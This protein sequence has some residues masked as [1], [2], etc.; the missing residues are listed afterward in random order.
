M[1]IGLNSIIFIQMIGF[2]TLL[3]ILNVILY[4]PV[5]R[6]IRERKK[7]IEN[8]LNQAGELQ[9]KASENEKAYK[10]KFEKSEASAK[11]EYEDIVLSALKEKEKTIEEE[12]AK[13]IEVIE[14]EKKEILSALSFELTKAKQ[15]SD[16]ISNK[17]YEQLVA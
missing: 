5:L 8:L 12:A 4:K 11:K 2:L 3:F 6:V 7:S 14:N 17:I 15:H 13:A 16:D 9:S 1:A 10:E